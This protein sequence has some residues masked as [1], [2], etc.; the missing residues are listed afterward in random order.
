MQS[1]GGSDWMT[2]DLAM[3]NVSWGTK[4][5]LTCSYKDWPADWGTPS[6]PVYV[7]FVRTRDGHTEQV[8]TWRGLPGKT[9]RLAAATATSRDDIA[10]VEVRT[11]DG[12]RVLKLTA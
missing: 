5:D 10:S 8:A 1:V 9:M 7:M 2:A 4:L 6:E 3:T 12:T 11:A